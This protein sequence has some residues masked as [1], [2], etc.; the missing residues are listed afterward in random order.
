MAR[1]CRTMKNREA[2]QDLIMVIG[3][4]NLAISQREGVHKIDHDFTQFLE[5]IPP[6]N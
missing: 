5:Q 2:L 6:G 1:D 4:A 3:R